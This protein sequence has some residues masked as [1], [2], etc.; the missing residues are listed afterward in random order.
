MHGLKEML[1]VILLCFC[2]FAGYGLGDGY[3][4]LIKFYEICIKFSFDLRNEGKSLIDEKRRRRNGKRRK[5]GERR[6]FQRLT[7]N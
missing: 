3:V 7:W 6:H 2:I 1:T 5:L 4:N